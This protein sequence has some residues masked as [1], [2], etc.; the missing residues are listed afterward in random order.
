MSLGIRQ[1]FSLTLRALLALWR[2]PW[3]V[4]ITLV[5]P[6]IWL[7]LFGALFKKVV[8]IPGFNG[9]SYL[10]F[11]TPGVVVMSALFAAGWNGMG[12][13]EAIDRGI[14]DR[15]LVTPVWRGALVAASC[16]HAAVV[17]LV[18]TVVIIA[19]AFAAG[20]TF[21]ASTVVVM[22]VLPVLLG[23]AVAAL[24]N[25]MALVTRQEES[26]IGAVQFVVLPAS[27]LSSGMMA[28]N[29]LPGWIHDIA[30]YNPVNWT[31]TAVRSPDTLL[32]GEHAGLLVALVL[33]CG[34]LATRA[35][36]VYQRAV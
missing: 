33:V 27:F 6:M 17:I 19:V 32:I 7:L 35:F 22:L 24:S 11:L 30:R 14:M 2:Q 3:F 26:L 8:E 31:V 29:L 25:A 12:L 5:Q 15:F 9:G 13:I 34:W 4:A 28:S 10:H 20:T 18:Q 1:T 21:P 36:R 23:G 16:V